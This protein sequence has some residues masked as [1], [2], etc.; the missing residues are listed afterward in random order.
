[1]RRGQVRHRR[2]R[3]VRLRPRRVGHQRLRLH[4]VAGREQLRLVQIAVR[5][6]AAGDVRAPGQADQPL[7]AALSQSREREGEG[8]SERE[9]ERKIV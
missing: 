3:R 2:E 6:G 1:M 9:M 4:H 7:A 5:V 8:G